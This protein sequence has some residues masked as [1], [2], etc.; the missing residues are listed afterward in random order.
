VPLGPPQVLRWCPSNI[1][2]ALAGTLTGSPTLPP[3]TNRA[4]F[5]S[6]TSAWLSVLSYPEGHPCRAGGGGGGQYH[7]ERVCRGG[8]W[9]A[10]LWT[11]TCS[12]IPSRSNY[13]FRQRRLDFRAR[14]TA[15]SRACPTTIAHHPAWHD[16]RDLRRDFALLPTGIRRKLHRRGLTKMW[17]GQLPSKFHLDRREEGLASCS[18]PPCCSNH[19]WHTDWQQ[20]AR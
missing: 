2:F 9:A 15:S 20:D 3:R 12:G 19:I 5:N 11:T 16:P 6:P 17:L 1:D 10:Q 8:G 4:I 18:G 7:L 13:R 14:F